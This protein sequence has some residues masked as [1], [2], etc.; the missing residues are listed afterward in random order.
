ML[1]DTY[2][3]NVDFEF[4]LQFD[5]F[6]CLYL[7]FLFIFSR[8]MPLFYVEVVQLF[9][10]GLTLGSLELEDQQIHLCCLMY[11]QLICFI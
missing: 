2:L 7:I 10:L 4:H 9:L 1:K 11:E 3:I 5:I 8:F 6:F